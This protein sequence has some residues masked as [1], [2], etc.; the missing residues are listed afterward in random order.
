MQK[1]VNYLLNIFF[2]VSGATLTCPRP[3]YLGNL[4]TINL[5][6][7]QTQDFKSK[8]RKKNWKISCRLLTA[9]RCFFMSDFTGYK[10]WNIYSHAEGNRRGGNQSKLCEACGISTK[11]ESKI[12]GAHQMQPQRKQKMKPVSV[13]TFYFIT[14]FF[15]ALQ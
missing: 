6:I 8:N 13:S 2:F 4:T 12:F 14:S 7:T 3:K 10:I 9:N 5:L 15:R 11:C 1:L